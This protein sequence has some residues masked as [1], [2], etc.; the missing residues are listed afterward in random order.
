MDHNV[1]HNADPVV[2]DEPR[3][4]RRVAAPPQGRRRM[5][6]CLTHRAALARVRCPR[7]EP[8]SPGC[9]RTMR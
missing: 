7:G 3:H 6:R 4:F 2:N 9:G 5:D 8:M 1:A